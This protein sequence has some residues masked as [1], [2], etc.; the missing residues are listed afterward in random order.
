[1]PL[2]KMGTR[3]V[4]LPLWR[5]DYFVMEV[6]EPFFKSGNKV[7][8]FFFVHKIPGGS[9]F[10]AVGHGRH[11]NGAIEEYSLLEFESMGNI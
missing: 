3:I 11:A 8:Y 9:M 7:Q 10:L 2:N 5:T 4:A 6:Q 1:M